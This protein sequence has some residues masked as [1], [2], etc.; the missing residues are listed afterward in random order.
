MRKNLQKQI[1]HLA[2]KLDLVDIRI[3]SLEEYQ[4][5]KGGLSP[6]ELLLDAKSA[7]V[8]LYP[9]DK[10]IKEYGHWHVVSLNKFISST[11]KKFEKLFFKEG[12]KYR[13]VQENEYDRKTLIGK[14]SFRQIASLA[15]LGSIGENQM[16]LHRKLGSRCV[17]GVILTSIEARKKKLKKIELCTHCKICRRQCP[18]GAL[19]KNYDKWKCKHRRKVLGRGCGILCVESC[20]VGGTS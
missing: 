19:K 15:G 1:R 13:G 3:V 5:I 4:Q 12:V 16:L 18:T 8:Y 9:L 6:E 20:P 11:N 17:I 14:I 10:L 2:S 7:V